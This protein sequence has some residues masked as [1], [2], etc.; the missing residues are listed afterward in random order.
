VQA[1]LQRVVR[2][3]RRA[4]G[5]TLPELLIATMLGLMV[6]G[7]AATVF[8]AAVRSQPGL[9]KRGDAISRAR[10]T[11]E[12]LIRE[13]R[14]GSA[15]YTATATQLAFLT[16]VD[17]GTCGGAHSST[18]MQCRVTY[19]CASNSCTRVEAKP[20]GT[21]PGVALTVVSGLS[22]S[23]VFSYSPTT[24]APKYIG[25]TFIFPGQNGDDAITVSDGAA[26]RNPTS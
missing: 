14:Q 22:S 13:L 3:A 16:Y 19:T 20:D 5:F 8:T 26:L 18:A 1:L 6:V 10:T 21:S 17:S 12:R 7:V 25:A 23:N 2:R 15:V 4:D 11:S 9:T 24:G